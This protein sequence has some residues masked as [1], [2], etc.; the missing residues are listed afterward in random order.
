MAGVYFVEAFVGVFGGA[1]G[2]DTLD[3]G[4]IDIPQ[5]QQRVSSDDLDMIIVG[6][7][8][9]TLDIAADDG[10]TIVIKGRPY[11]VAAGAEPID[12]ARFG[13]TAFLSELDGR[14]SVLCHQDG[15][16]LVGTDLFSAANIHWCVDGAGAVW[17][18]THLGL[19]CQVRRGQLSPDRLGYLSVLAGG[20]LSK[21]RT[22]YREIWRLQGGQALTARQDDCAVIA[23]E[24]VRYADAAEILQSHAGTFRP[25]TAFERFSELLR[26]AVAREKP[27]ERTA[28]MLSGGLDST[29]IAMDEL[30]QK[31][32]SALTYGTTRSRDVRGAKA[33]ARW[34]GLPHE[35]IPYGGWDW[36]AYADFVVD[37]S[38]GLSGLQTAHNIV[39]FDAVRNRFDLALLGF[40]GD[41]Q[42]GS[43][44]TDDKSTW[45]VKAF[46][47]GF[48]VDCGFA[49]RYDPELREIMAE[50]ET[51]FPYPGDYAQ[52]RNYVFSDLYMRQ[53]TRMA[54]AIGLCS[55]FLD[56]ATPLYHRELLG[57]SFDMPG[58]ASIA[59]KFFKDWH[60][61]K[62]DR[63]RAAGRPFGPRGAF[64]RAEFMVHDLLDRVVWRYEKVIGDAGSLSNPE[65]LSFTQML[66]TS[67]PWLREIDAACPSAPELTEI[68]ETQL[69]LSNPILPL[70]TLSLIL[71]YNRFIGA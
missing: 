58:D 37:V 51:D 64:Q 53:P 24:V 49:D 62:K 2:R 35:K 32:V 20:I 47:L 16:L 63:F 7:V 38:G 23:H 30:G 70:S 28:L 29:A 44:A 21:D 65:I 19:L 61:C 13:D 25:E 48:D 34:L 10:R 8:A 56:V 22:P 31:D 26:E 57:F 41:T 11:P 27:S 50:I 71:A 5:K 42:T 6:A 60:R 15:A 43:N 68:F 66:K 40:Y 59:R 1:L 55:L 67:A 17:F 9:P 46:E 39:A 33:Y 12:A 14:F 18:A 69:A 52:H 4:G 36:S 54:N 45:F 3:F